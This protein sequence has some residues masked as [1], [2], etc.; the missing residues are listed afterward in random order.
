MGNSFFINVI[1]HNKKGQT[2]E[3]RKDTNKTF[4]Y[5]KKKWSRTRPPQPQKRTLHKNE[6][7]TGNIMSPN[8]KEWIGTKTRL[9]PD[10]GTKNYDSVNHFVFFDNVDDAVDGFD[11]EKADIDVDVGEEY[12]FVHIR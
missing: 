1:S 4:V 8:C 10:D 11:D 12:G 6:L 5:L 3:N 9:S 7:L 2:K